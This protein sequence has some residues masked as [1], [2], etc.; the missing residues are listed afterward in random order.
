M[1]PQ[2]LATLNAFLVRLTE[3]PPVPVDEEADRAIRAACARQPQ[4]AYLL[5][6]RALL[7]EQALAEAQ[8][9][10]AALEAALREARAGQTCPD[11][12]HAPL[13]GFGHHASV[14]PVA[15]LPAAPQLA[16]ASAPVVAGAPA[17]GWLSGTSGVWG[18]V[19]AT[20]A[21]VAA[22]AFLYQGLSHLLGGQAHPVQAAS[23]AAWADSGSSTLQPGYFDA[24]APDAE[25]FAED[26]DGADDSSDDSL[27]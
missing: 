1:T 14:P 9:Q 3:Q 26:L 2:E 21:G 12:V 24:P 4:A 6:Q 22:G 16:P 10:Q 13:D 15:A 18:N 20:A 27:S 19:A 5:T 17:A 7:L 11:F 23:G 25:R 8:R